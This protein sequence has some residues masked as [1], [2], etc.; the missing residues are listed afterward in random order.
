LGTPVLGTPDLRA[1]RL[2]RKLSS[3]PKPPLA[4]NAHGDVYSLT[5]GRAFGRL[6]MS[7]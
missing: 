1:G 3:I 5:G 7:T 2:G 6:Q 4:Q